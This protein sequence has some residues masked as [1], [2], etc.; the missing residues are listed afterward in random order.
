MGIFKINYKKLYWITEDDNGSDLCIHGDLIAKIGEETIEESCNVSAT[1]L[2]LLK[3]LTEDHIINEDNQMMPCCGHFRI[4]NE[5]LTNVTIIGCPY[6]TDW[7]IIHQGDTVRLITESGK[8]TIVPILEYKNQV[9]KFVDEIE[10][11]YKKSIP[12]IIPHDEF[13]RNGYIAFWNEWHRRRNS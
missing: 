1:A 2:Y 9:Y 4:A 7:S 8:E 11:Y 12:R 10:E 3:S 13:D 6:G 5:S